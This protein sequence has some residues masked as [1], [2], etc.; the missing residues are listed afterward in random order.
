MTRST[1]RSASGPEIRY[2]KSGDTSMSA[3]ASRIALY[4]M[5]CASAYTDEAQAHRP[6][7]VRAPEPADEWRDIAPRRQ[8]GPQRA[9]QVGGGQA[10]REERDER[11]DHADR[12]QVA[13]PR[14]ERPRRPRVERGEADPEDGV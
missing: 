7:Q 9:D 4:S 10:P 14:G 11:H 12:R 13:E 1:S 5:S 8:W 2:L 3:A 6:D